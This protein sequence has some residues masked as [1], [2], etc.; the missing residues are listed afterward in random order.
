MTFDVDRVREDFPILNRKINGRQLIYFDNAATTQRPKQVV[1]AIARFY[2]HSNA[3][4]HRGM[5]ALSQEASQMFEEA[6]ETV[7]KFINADSWQEIV[8]TLNTTDSINLVAWG[9]GLKNLSPGDEILLTVM[10]HH[11]NMLPWRIV[12][13]K[14]G[15]VVKYV[16]IDDEG[17]INYDDLEEKL[18]ER[19][20]ED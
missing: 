20:K 9:W 6:H 13:S 1:E 2:L 8:L 17:R 7:A 14:L 4:V 3:N 11:S 10:D 18:N 5:H 19:T 15:A 12:A 16:D